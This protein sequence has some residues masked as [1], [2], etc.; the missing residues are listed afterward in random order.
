MN[1]ESLVAV[2]PCLRSYNTPGR[3]QFHISSL[4]LFL[5]PLPQRVRQSSTHQIH[6]TQS[7]R[8]AAHNAPHT[9]PL[10]KGLSPPAREQQI[11]TRPRGA[12]PRAVGLIALEVGV[13]CKE[14]DGREEHGEELERAHVLCGDERGEHGWGKEFSVMSV[15]QSARISHD[16]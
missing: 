13:A 7:H 2:F 12:D 10:H 16:S 9:P 11:Q 15:S 14:Q 3:E 5:L 1:S 4:L 8:R 6:Q